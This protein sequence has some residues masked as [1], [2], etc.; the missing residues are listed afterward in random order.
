MLLAR[1]ANA[2]AR[3][4]SLGETA[5]MWAAAENHPEAVRALIE[6]GADPNTR[7]DKLEYPKDRFGLEGVTTILPHG[8]W[9]ALMYAGR[10][11]SLEAART[12][13]EMG[14]DLNLA[15]PDG[16]TALELAIL[17]GHFDTAAM[18]TEKGADPNI[19]D[20]TGMAALYAAVDMST[21][22]E[23]Y[24]RPGRKSTDKLSAVDLMPILLAHGANPNATLKSAT[25][26]RAHTPGE[27]S[28][29]EGTTPLMRAA[30]NG[31]VAAMRVLMAHGAD[32]SLKQKNGTTT[33]M[34]AAGRR[35][36]HGSVRQ[37]LR[38]RGGIARG[39]EVPG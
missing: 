33:L 19:A 9:T 13:A 27:P 34:F 10:Q 6:H 31:D 5:L 37:G 4:S 24:G 1:G 36:R 14:A 20:S 39:R 23:I 11:G 29:G 12:L 18:L 17:N 28:L 30:K 25:L 32:A 16:T 21:L 8:S 3:E 26:T 38:D 15:D 2:N 35:P 22:G 7:S